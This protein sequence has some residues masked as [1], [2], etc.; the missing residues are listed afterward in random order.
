M[1]TYG[2]FNYETLYNMKFDDYEHTIEIVNKLVKEIK[3]A[4]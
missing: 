3:D 1:T 2:A 4:G